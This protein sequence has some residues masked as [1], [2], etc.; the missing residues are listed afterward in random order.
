MS[1]VHL[2]PRAV[3]GLASLLVSTAFLFGL[4]LKQHI[5]GTVLPDGFGEVQYA[6]GLSDPTAMAFAPDPC[7]SSGTPVHRLFVCEKSGTV[8]V[9]RNGVLQATPFLTVTADTRG[10]RGLDGICFD[11][12]FAT[13]GY[14]YVYYTIN[15]ADPSLPTHNRLSRFTADPAHPDQSLA[16]SETPIMEMDDLSATSYVHNGAALRFGS[17]GKLYV[18]TGENGNPPNSQS[19]TTVLGKIL[20]INPIPENADGSNPDSTFPTDNPFYNTTTGKNRA[21]YVLGLRNPFTFAFQSTTGRMF[22]DDVG[23][24]TWEEINEGLSGRNFGW[25]TTEGPVIPPPNGITNPIYAYQHFTGTPMGCAITGGDFYNPPALCSGDPPYGFPSSYVGQYFF[26][27]Y[28]QNWIYTMDPNLIDP[29][30]PYGF[31]IV[32][33]FASGIHGSPVYL[34]IG[35]DNNLYY[36]SRLDN[37]IYQIHYPA[38]LS[39]SIDTDPADVL[40]GQ[41]WPATFT[42]SATGAQPLHYQWWRDNVPIPGATDSPTYTLQSPTVAADNGATIKCRVTNSFGGITSRGALL[43]VITEQPPVPVIDSPGPYTYYDVGDTLTFSGSAVDGH[44]IVTGDPQDG[45]MGPNAFTWQILF[46]HHSFS[47]PNHHTHPFFGPTTGIAGATVTLNFG[48]TD[49]D[50]WY[51]IFFTATDSYGLSTTVYRDILPHHTLLSLNTAPVPLKIRLFGVNK[52]TPLDFWS[53]VNTTWSIGVD[54]P[55]TLNGLTYDFYSWSDG[56]SWY[57]NINAPPTNTDYVANFWKRPAYGTLT[58]NPNPVP[59]TAGSSTGVTT[60]FWSSAQ[61]TGVE[62][63]AD[64]PSGGLVGA[65]GPGNFSEVTGNWIQEGTTLFL[66]DVSNNQP[67]TADFTLASITLHTTA[68][69]SAS[70]TAYPNPFVADSN[71]LGETTLAWTSSGVNTVE[72]HVDAPNGNAFVSSGPGSFTA[73]TPHWVQNGT[74][75]YLQDVSNG[76]PLTSANTL[77]TLTMA[78]LSPTPKGSI[79]ALPNPFTADAQGLGDTVISWTSYGTSRVEIHINAPDGPAFAGGNPGTFSMA[80][81]HWV[82][83]GMTFYLQNVSDGLPLTAANTLATVTMTAAIPPSGSITAQ[84]NPFPPDPNGFGETTITWSSAG[85]SRVE[86][87]LGAPD[88]TMFAASDSGTYSV[89]TGHWVLSGM[90]FYLQDVSNNQPLTAANTL[91]TVTVTAAP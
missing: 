70:M 40:V 72:I 8:R 63:H 36:I 13:N 25:P 85:T 77:A 54:T 22:I 43:T 48:E 14:V 26:L 49:P 80:T 60:I 17:D 46:E 51:R 84:P 82:T 65:S 19:L 67:L 61:T 71:G 50:V 12:N 10:E 68:T 45:V 33:S 5:A 81:D 47:N 42:V 53:V 83:D 91:A 24:S 55:Q 41:G 28:C 16:G 21:I 69:P 64:S 86:V 34:T 11:P 62:V 1:N 6:N 38:T 74:T 58:A 89:A 3:R 52:D 37:A 59:L 2:R 44:D 76:K 75:F 18:S 32:T 4:A 7:P 90:T 66:Q 15:Q 20:R 39:P 9:F 56:G 78:A 23:A 30:S 87:H 29:A 79:T 27:D 31:H 88:G 73:T 57:H 35:P